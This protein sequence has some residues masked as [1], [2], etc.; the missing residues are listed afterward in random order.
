MA[1]EAVIFEKRQ[2]P[3]IITLNRPEALNAFSRKTSRELSEIWAEVR[4]DDN[5]WVA[6]VTGA[7]EKAF[8]VGI[9]VRESDRELEHMSHFE[10]WR[11]IPGGKLTARQNGCMKPVITAVNGMCAGGGFYFVGD[12]DIVICSEN[13]TFFDP[14]VTYGRVAALE[15][16]SLTRRIP[17]GEVMRIALMGTTWRMDA[18]RAYQIG[19]A[20]EVTPLAGLLPRALEIAE[21]M[22]QN[23]PMSLQG[24]VEALWKS[25]DMGRTAAMDYGL[26]VAQRNVFTEDH[27]E[28][29]RAFAEKRKPTWKNR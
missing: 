6:V 29:R 20:Q 15:P 27:A 23:S 14:H 9:D 25:L 18:Q 11:E 22:C 26:L 1:Y 16:I 24:T 19:L 3:A 17:F 4:G 12:S 2:H 10:R 5:V 28:G 7:G 8:C 21:S 13:A